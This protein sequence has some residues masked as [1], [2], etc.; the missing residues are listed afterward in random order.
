MTLELSPTYA[1]RWAHRACARA[2]AP[3]VAA[4]PP[5]GASGWGVVQPASVTAPSTRA[6]RVLRTV[7]ATW[8]TGE[9]PFAGAGTGTLQ[10]TDGGRAPP[11]PADGRAASADP[12]VAG[13]E[14]SRRAVADPD[15]TEDVAQVHLDRALADAE[16]ARDLLVRQAARDVGEHLALTVAER[17][18]GPAPIG[19]W[20]QRARHAGVERGVPGRRRPHR[21]EDV[22]RLAVLEQ[23]ADG[24]GLD[25]VA[26]P[27]GLRER[28]EHD[29]GSQLPDDRHGL[30][31]VARLSD[32]A[33]V[34]ARVDDGAQPGTHEPVVVHDDDGRHRSS[35]TG[36]ASCHCVPSPGADRTRRT[37]PTS[38]ARSASTRT[39]KCPSTPGRCA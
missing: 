30:G 29:D 20:Q 22:T 34:A 3:A 17:R 1:V 12:V 28:R 26:H 18:A 6:P 33:E 5:L 21:V 2:S 14:R 11:V 9:S 15:L 35:S 4:G 37:A 32:D 8:T 36:S 23:V 10:C 16:G 27:I 39:P 25:G 31:P 13:P 38:V 19:R 24:A 7:R